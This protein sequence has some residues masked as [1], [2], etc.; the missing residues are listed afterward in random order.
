MARNSIVV[1]ND[2]RGRFIEGVLAAGQTPKPGQHISLKSDGTYEAWNGAADG[3]RDEV[4]ILCEDILR[5]RTVDDAYAAGDRF[6]AYIPLPG[7]EVQCLFG[8]ASGTADDVLVGDK[9]IID[10][11]TGKVIVTTGSPESE[12]YRA[13]EAITDPTADQLLLCRFTG[14]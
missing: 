14:H 4:I 12:P 2:P 8:N 7:D 3:E 9:M 5:G 6:R 10:D 11:G 13:L 1:S